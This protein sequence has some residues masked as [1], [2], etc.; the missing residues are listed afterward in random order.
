M[1]TNSGRMQRQHKVHIKAQRSSTT[2]E[3][4]RTYD[5]SWQGQVHKVCSRHEQLQSNYYAHAN[6]IRESSARTFRIREFEQMGRGRVAKRQG[7]LEVGRG[8]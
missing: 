5:R 3:P 2:L 1:F 7:S 4:Y 6:F 8:I